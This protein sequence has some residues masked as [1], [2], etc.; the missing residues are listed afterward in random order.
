[1]KKDLITVFGI[2]IFG[3]ILSCL[4][5]GRW[6]FDG[7]MSIIESISS[8]NVVQFAAGGGWGIPKSV[9]DFIDAIVTMLLW[10]Y[11]FLESPWAIFLKVALWCI[12][13]AT[14]YGL[15]ELGNSV[16]SG[17]VGAFRSAIGH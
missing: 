4:C 8:F 7:E 5:S 17:L 10:A 16:V 6:L 2:F 11:P 9:L 15:I 3:T 12:S 1:M 14:V 13:I